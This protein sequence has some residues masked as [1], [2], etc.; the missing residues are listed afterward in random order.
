LELFRES[1]YDG[2]PEEVFM[3]DA[4]EVEIEEVRE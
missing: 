4:H 3:G 1:E 2:P